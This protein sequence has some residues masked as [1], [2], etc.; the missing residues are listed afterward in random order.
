M[1]IAIETRE[2]Q[3]LPLQI[4]F[5]GVTAGTICIKSCCSRAVQMLP[6]LVPYGKTG[7]ADGGPAWTRFST[8]YVGLRTAGIEDSGDE[9]ILMTV[10]IHVCW[11]YSDLYLRAEVIVRAP[12]THG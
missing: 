7:G 2:L 1:D 9:Y 3:L 5:D 11:E 10:A 4:N 12:N 8:D 6:L